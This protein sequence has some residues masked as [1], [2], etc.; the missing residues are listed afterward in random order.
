MS[1]PASAPTLFKFSQVDVFGSSPLRGNPLAV[2]HGAG[3]LTSEQMQRFARWTNLSETTFL[4]PPSHP[5]ADYRVRI[6]TPSE[7]FD[8][9]GHPT[10]GSAHA[11]LEAG[12][13]PKDP[14]F[15]VQECGV[16]L[17]RL[18]T[19][20]FTRTAAR[21]ISFEAPALRRSGAVAP[22]VLERVIRVLG[23]R[24][25]QVLAS[26]W[27]DNGPGWLGVLLPDAQTVLDL[28][29]DFASMGDL[30]ISV[31]GAQA[32]SGDG[33]DY[34]VR[35]FI[36][37]TGINEDPVTGSANA[38]LAQWLMGAGLAPARY[39]ARQGTAIGYDGRIE[40]LSDDSSVWVGGSCV[41]VVAGAVAL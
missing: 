12:G 4:L 31:I 2:V 13:Q 18:R 25:D 26:N 40:L 7:E 35:A 22:E 32:D 8:F 19:D 3:S 41:T 29:P 23:V 17:V 34:E 1:E 39:T 6:F 14:A 10:L 30:C 16:G 33:P 24:A 36:P 15:V 37:D 9:A 27:I 38:G 11:W 20:D 21:T 5:D 28:T